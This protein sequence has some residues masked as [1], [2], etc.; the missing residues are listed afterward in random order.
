MLFSFVVVITKLTI[1]SMQYT[2]S[3]IHHNIHIF[4]IGGPLNDDSWVVLPQFY[5]ISHN[6]EG[7]SIHTV[8]QHSVDVASLLFFFLPCLRQLLSFLFLIYGA[9]DC[10]YAL[11]SRPSCIK[12]DVFRSL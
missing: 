8:Y 9:S 11:E 12:C 3:A 4:L 2:I 1:H 5:T 10:K 7:D 6:Q